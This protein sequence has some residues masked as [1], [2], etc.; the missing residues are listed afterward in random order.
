MK[1]RQMALAFLREAHSDLHVA[2]VLLAE[3][4]HARSVEHSQHAVEKAIKAALFLKNIS[5]TNEHFVSEI[6][7]KNY[8]DHP[9][10]NE[11]VAKAQI[12]EN[13]GTLTEYPYWDHETDSIVSPYEEYD[14]AI[15]KAFYDDAHWIY[16]QIAVYLN[17]VYQVTLPPK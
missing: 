4:E 8:G 7:E 1:W 9:A 12:L 17:H 16:H 13:E 11:I 6:F 2:E 3:N 10:I 14:Q 5:I 15:A